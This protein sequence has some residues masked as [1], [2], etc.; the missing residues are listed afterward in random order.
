MAARDPVCDAGGLAPCGYSAMLPLL[1]RFAATRAAWLGADL[2]AGLFRLRA[3]ALPTAIAYAAIIGLPP[4]TG[5]DPPSCRR[6]AT[7]SSAP[8]GSSWSARIRRPV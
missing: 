6:W 5:L 2:L 7:P 4:Q 8:P 1:G 3:V